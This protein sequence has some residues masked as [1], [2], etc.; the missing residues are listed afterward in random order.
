[1]SPFV[2]N[3]ALRNPHVQAVLASMRLRRPF[4]MRRARKLLEASRPLVLDCGAGVRLQGYYAGPSHGA[5][6]AK[7]DMPDFADAKS[8]MSPRI[9][10]LIHGWE[11]SADSTYQ[12][13]AAAHLYARGFDVFRLNLR[14]H[15]ASHHLNVEVFHSCRLD[16]V[17]GAV[18][19]IARRLPQHRLYLAGFS[20]GGNFALRVAARARKANLAIERVV[21]VCP[22]LDPEHTLEALESGWLGYRLHFVGKWKRSL[23]L[24]QSCHPGIYDFRE[25]LALKTL[26]EMTD[27]LVRHHSEFADL[28]AYLKG[29]GIVDGALD[30]LSVPS[31][32]ILA[33]D[34]PIIPF[35]DAGRLKAPQ[36]LTIETTTFGG[37]CGFLQGYGLT[38]WIDARI[39]D[40]L[41]SESRS[42]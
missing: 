25:L 7:G 22:V 34:D 26:T 38:S 42:A 13:S 17:V 2:P 20:L 19:A 39:L 5:S 23:K 10:V 18:Q 40:A 12:L 24:K 36:C 27:Y 35:A 16:E 41:T 30:E 4:V 31:H 29:Y 1:M 11:G 33:I 15:G 32:V 3:R 9:V 8:G 6:Q 28:A 21:A 14:D 37:H